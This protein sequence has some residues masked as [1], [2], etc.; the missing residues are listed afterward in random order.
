[1][2]QRNHNARVGGSSPSSATNFYSQSSSWFF[3][4]GFLSASDSF[5]LDEGEEGAD[6]SGSSFFLHHLLLPQQVESSP[7]QIATLERQIH[8]C[9]WTCHLP[10]YYH[11]FLG[12]LASIFL[13]PPCPPRMVTAPLF[14]LSELT[15]H[16]LEWG[17]LS[18]HSFCAW[19]ILLS[20]DNLYSFH[21]CKSWLADSQK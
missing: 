15:S 13:P 12:G 21:D 16:F 19:Y 7:R 3:L 10:S 5:I 9:L 8:E 6:L 1:M 20:L 11:F 2:M 4:A 18:F 17:L 14:G